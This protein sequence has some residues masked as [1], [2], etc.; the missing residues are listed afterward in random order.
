[1]YLFIYCSFTENISVF[2][3][4]NRTVASSNGI[5]C[6]QHVTSVGICRC[7]R[8]PWI[9]GKQHI[10]IQRNGTRRDNAVKR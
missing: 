9:P 3:R 8:F 10:L 5:R 6:A 7:H 2:A 4:G 1:M